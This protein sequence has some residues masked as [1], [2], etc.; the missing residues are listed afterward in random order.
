MDRRTRTVIASVIWVVPILAGFVG[1]TWLIIP[2]SPRG[3]N[4]GPSEGRDRDDR[5]RLQGYWEG[6]RVERNGKTLYEGKAAGQARVRFVGDAVTFEDRDAQ[7][8]GTF[9]VDP[10]RTPK[11]FDLT[12]IEGGL[13]VTYPAGIYQLSGDTFRLSFA[14]PSTERPTSFETSPGSGRTLFIYRRTRP[15]P[16]S[17][18][19]QR[20]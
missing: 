13:S 10:H 8:N 16:R 1:A 4:G 6:I 20:L 7:L 14:F 5:F 12:V 18:F 19:D 15:E 3:I 2:P 9:E 11:T 17:I